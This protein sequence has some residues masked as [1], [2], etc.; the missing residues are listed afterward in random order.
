MHTSFF[1][2][3]LLFSTAGIFAAEQ[4]PAITPITNQHELVRYG[5]ELTTEERF[6]KDKQTLLPL[7]RKYGYS[8]TDISVAQQAMIYKMLLEGIEE[9]E[10][11]QKNKQS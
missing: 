4:K 6:K 5:R 9:F 1:V 3:A 10:K 2:V 11:T 8:G 7:L